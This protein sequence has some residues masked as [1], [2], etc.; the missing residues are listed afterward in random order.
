EKQCENHIEYGIRDITR[1][2][3]RDADKT[4]AEGGGAHCA[5]NTLLELAD[6]QKEFPETKLIWMLRK[7]NVEDTYGGEE[8]DS[9]EAREAI[10]K[11]IHSLVDSGK[12]KVYTPFYKMQVK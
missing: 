3:K 2:V 7:K 5:I 12:V 11:K 1:S 4:V 6:L 8:K 9:I 10:V